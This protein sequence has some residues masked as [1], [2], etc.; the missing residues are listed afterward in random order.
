L[1]LLVIEE[2]A[3]AAETLRAAGI[4]CIQGNAASDPVLAAA[5]IAA[6]RILFVAI[7]AAFEAGQIVEQARRAQ[8]GLEIVARAHF[9]AEVDHLRKLGANAVIMGEREIALAMLD[10]AGLRRDG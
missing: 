6:A 4:E 2:A 3:D 9:D 5:N 7:P 1:P 8:P 10:Y